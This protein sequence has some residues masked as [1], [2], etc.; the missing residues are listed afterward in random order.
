MACSATSKKGANAL[1]LPGLKF[2]VRF[3]VPQPCALAVA[4][5]EAVQAHCK[6][7]VRSGNLRTRDHRTPMNKAPTQATRN[8][9]QIEHSPPSRCAP[10]E[11]IE[12][13]PGFEPTGPPQSE[14]CFRLALL[15]VRPCKVPNGPG[16]MDP[17]VRTHSSR[18]LSGC[19]CGPTKGNCTGRETNCLNR[20]DKVKCMHTCMDTVT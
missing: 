11:I 13:A 17:C 6:L 14:R 9:L 15:G 2:A 1:Q 16:E 4:A 3:R 20:W 5:V 10:L 7:C 8:M 18:E 12:A 19:G